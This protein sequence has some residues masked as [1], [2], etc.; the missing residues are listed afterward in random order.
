VAEPSWEGIIHTSKSQLQ[1]YLQCSQ[2]YQYQYVLAAP[3]EAMPAI[4][5]F[6][7][8]LHRAVARYYIQKQAGRDVSLEELDALFRFSWDDEKGDLPLL[9]TRGSDEAAMRSQG[10][11]LLQCFMRQVKPRVIEAVEEPFIAGLIDP[12]TGD[13]LPIKLVG[14]L[15]LRECDGQGNFIV[16]ELKASARK[17]TERQG[18]HHLDGAVYGYAMQQ[19][20]YTTGAAQ[21]LIRFDVLVKT[22]TPQFEQYYFNKSELDFRKFLRLATKVLRGID[23]G[24][25]IP[26]EGWQ[27]TTCPFQTR[28]RQEQVR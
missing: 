24:L 26:H 9:M 20:G 11:E 3:W 7:R 12:D 25:F 15:D 1:T 23:R 19:A 17:Y 22:K 27:C 5:L 8:A 6:G 2:R 4:L 18:E 28:C 14:V 10:R 16:A 13:V 21:V